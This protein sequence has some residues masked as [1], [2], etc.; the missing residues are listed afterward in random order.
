MKFWTDG[1]AACRTQVSAE[2]LSEGVKHTTPISLDVSNEAALEAEVAKHDLVI[3]YVPSDIYIG[4][5]TLIY[6]IA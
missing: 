2:K 3:S 4:S 1:I 6:C 5:S